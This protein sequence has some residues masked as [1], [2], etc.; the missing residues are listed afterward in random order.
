MYLILSCSSFFCWFKDD[1]TIT[2]NIQV[3]YLSYFNL[4]ELI[5]IVDFIKHSVIYLNFQDEN[6]NNSMEIE[7]NNYIVF[8]FFKYVNL[9]FKFVKLQENFLV[10]VWNVSYLKLIAR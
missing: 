8:N 5:I 1:N 10:I 3:F 4:K 2:A 6:A 9:R 7:Y